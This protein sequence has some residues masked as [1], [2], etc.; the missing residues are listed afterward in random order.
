MV[1]QKQ[2]V[3]YLLPSSVLHLLVLSL[4]VCGV[5]SCVDGKAEAGKATIMGQ[6]GS[7]SKSK[8]IPKDWHLVKVVSA[9]LGEEDC[10]L[11][12][13]CLEKSQVVTK[14]QD[15]VYKTML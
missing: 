8:L 4:K 9:I 14:I 15:A 6:D 1:N 7:K 2:L 11:L 3:R 5:W 12:L 13:Y 10:L